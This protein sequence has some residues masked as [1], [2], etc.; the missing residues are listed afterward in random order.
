[1][2]HPFRRLDPCEE[3]RNAGSALWLVLFG[4]RS[5]FVGL[6]QPERLVVCGNGGLAQPSFRN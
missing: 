2:T 5:P 3:N 6:D 4:L 1:M